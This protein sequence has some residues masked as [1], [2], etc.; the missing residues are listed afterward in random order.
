MDIRS[1]STVPQP[2]IAPSPEAV[3]A[4]VTRLEHPETTGGES[5]VAMD[6]TPL[7]SYSI[8]P[9]PPAALIAH[10]QYTAAVLKSLYQTYEV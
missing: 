3:S 5:P 1:F 10:N 4:P 9:A 8:S 7:A 6:T 2:L